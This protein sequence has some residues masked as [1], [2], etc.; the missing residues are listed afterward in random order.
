MFRSP[1]ESLSLYVFRNKARS[2]YRLIIA[3]FRTGKFRKNCWAKCVPY[4]EKKKILRSKRDVTGFATWW[5]ECSVM[6]MKKKKGWK[7]RIHWSVL[8]PM[9]QRRGKTLGVLGSQEFSSLLLPAQPK[10]SCTH[11]TKYTT[12]HYSNQNAGDT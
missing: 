7:D 11:G 12:C 5:L 3:G 8:E 10:L 4:P 1:W 2:L 9:R 6:R